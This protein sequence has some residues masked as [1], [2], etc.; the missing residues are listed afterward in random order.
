[1]ST[2]KKQKVLLASLGTRGDMEPFIAVGDL[3]EKRGHEVVYVVPAQF[4]PLLPESALVH[5]LSESFIHLIE[6][7]QGKL[8]MGKA[9]WWRKLKAMIYLYR[10]G[11]EV[12]RVLVRQQSEAIA[13]EAPDIVIHHPKCSY[14]VLWSMAT[15]KPSILLSAVPYVLH[16]VKGHAH[17]GFPEYLDSSLSRFTYGIANYGFAT[18]VYDVQKNLEEKLGFSKSEIKR[19]LMAK[20]IMYTISPTLFPR[21]DYWPDQAQ[22]V[23]FPEKEKTPASRLEPSLQDFIDRHGKI[24]LLTF[25]SMVNSEPERISEFFYRILSKLKIP[26]IVN[27]AS[28]GLI[29]IPEYEKRDDFFFA[30]GLPYETVMEKVY[31]VIHHGGSGTTHM[32]LK[33]GCP[34]LIIPHIIDQFAW[35]RRVSEAGAGPKG[36]SINKLPSQKLKGLSRDLFNNE[37]Y[38][39]RAKSISGSMADEQMEKNLYAF[40]L[41]R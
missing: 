15:G 7:R 31:A 17:V 14:P 16:P 23:G 12:N 36:L 34:T 9:P 13:V 21:P 38:L 32:A 27:T 30:E 8:V 20:K 2:T 3:L 1:M 33:H 11:K 39:H 24:V 25:G 18:T 37:S 10:K 35:N 40:I 6:S 26:T 28:G 19:S 22:V 41:K 5:P 29:K 4:T